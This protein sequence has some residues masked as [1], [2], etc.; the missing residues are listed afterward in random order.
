MASTNKFKQHKDNPDS[1]FNNEEVYKDKT[2]LA[3]V[4]DGEVVQTML[5]D[6]RLSAILQSNPQI[7]EVPVKTDPS[8]NGPHIGWKYDGNEF[9][10]PY[11]T[12]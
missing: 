2:F 4:I 6:T 8:F 12:D 5:C 7:V 10:H 11:L 1:F 3:F 9:K